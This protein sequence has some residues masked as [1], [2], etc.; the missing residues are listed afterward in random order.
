MKDTEL[1]IIIELLKDSRR[2]DREIARKVGVSQ[3][4]VT[5]MI[6]K[7]KSEGYIKEFTIIPDFSKLGFEIMSIIL[8]DVREKTTEREMEDTREKIRNEQKENPNALLFGYTGMGLNSTRASILLAKNYSELSSFNS[9]ARN[10]PLVKVDSI[11]SFDISLVG[12]NHYLPL[13]LSQLAGYL[14]RNLSEM[15]RK[16]D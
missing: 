15:G 13:T 16:S 12:E 4:T 2:S 6:K 5:R 8:S 11:R 3:P 7:L 10:H 9:L 1:R 14:E